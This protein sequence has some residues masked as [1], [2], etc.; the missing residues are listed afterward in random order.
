MTVKAGTHM[1]RVKV[2]PGH[3]SLFGKR[4]AIAFTLIELLVVIA[5]IAIL[6]AMLLPALANAKEKANR[7]GCV[8]NMRQI[9]LAMAMYTADNNDCMPWMQWYNDY[10]PSWIYMP[11]GG[12]APDPYRLVNGVLEDNTNDFPYIQQGLYFPY[13]KNRNAYYC[14]ADKK[15]NDN[16][17]RRRQRVSSYIMNG[18]VWNFS[19][20]NPRNKH[21]ITEFKPDAYCQWEPRV[22]N[23]GGYFAYNPGLDASQNPA[24]EEGIGD[25][26]I[27]GAVILGFDSR[28]HFIS[29][30]KF[31]DEGRN[32]PG[33]LW[34]VPNT[35]T[36]TGQ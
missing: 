6:A 25:R 29:F 36:G 13:V 26:H 2:R 34:C 11:K 1:N 14:P 19:S 8:N 30:K 18:A 20:Y 10:G 15:T 7:I 33:L 31:E 12:A 27:K 24:G 23:Y 32:F 22:N 35:K 4:L 21:K 5:I 3:K 17:K 9:G 28:A 16:F